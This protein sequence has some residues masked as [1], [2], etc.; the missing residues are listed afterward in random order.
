MATQ[1]D[2]VLLTNQLAAVRAELAAVQEQ[3]AGQ[4]QQVLQ[5]LAA[6]AT[7]LGQTQARR[8]GGGE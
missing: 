4:P 5:Q 8:P 7:Q 2:V 3:A 1:E 6:V